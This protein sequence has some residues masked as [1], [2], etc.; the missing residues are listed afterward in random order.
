ML[1]KYVIKF[2]DKSTLVDH[3]ATHSDVRNYKCSICPDGRYFK[4]K[5][6]LSHH[7]IFHYEPKYSCSHCDHKRYTKSDSSRHEQTHVKK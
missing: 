2:A 4:T 6:Q 5:F 7:V 3:Q 1:V